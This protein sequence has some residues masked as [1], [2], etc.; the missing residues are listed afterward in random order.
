[1]KNENQFLFQNG[2]SWIIS[3]LLIKNNKGDETGQPIP[4]VIGNYV[5][6]KDVRVTNVRFVW[7]EGKVER[8]DL[9]PEAGNYVVTDVNTTGTNRICM[10]LKLTNIKG[11]NNV[12]NFIEHGGTWQYHDLGFGCAMRVPTRPY[13]WRNSVDIRTGNN[14]RSEVVVHPANPLLT[15]DK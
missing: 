1:M 2:M 4:S 10:A 11:I 3:A 8:Y 13:V 7:D 9:V 14:T 15:G 6:L 5:I 12:I